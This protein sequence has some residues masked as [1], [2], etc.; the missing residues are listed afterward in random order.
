MLI[1]FV[2]DDEVHRRPVREPKSEG[3]ASNMV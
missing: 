2:P 1:E 3:Q